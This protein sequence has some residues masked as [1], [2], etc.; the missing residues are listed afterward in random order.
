MGTLASR[1]V[2]ASL[3]MICAEDELLQEEDTRTLDLCFKSSIARQAE[4]ANSQSAFTTMVA[5]LNLAWF[6]TGS[7]AS[8]LV[9]VATSGHGGLGH[10]AERVIEP[11]MSNKELFERS[12]LVVFTL[13]APTVM[14]LASEFSTRPLGKP[15]PRIERVCRCTVPTD[16]QRGKTWVVEHNARHGCAVRDV[17]IAAKCSLCGTT[18]RLESSRLDGEIYA[19]HGRYCV[20]ICYD[21][22]H[23]WHHG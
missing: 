1:S 8:F 6:K 3:F 17:Q 7:W 14:L 22:Q 2:E 13:E 10:V 12:D 16:A 20:K 21:G 23:G 15:L 9:E 19:R 5:S 18:W 11:W 4:H